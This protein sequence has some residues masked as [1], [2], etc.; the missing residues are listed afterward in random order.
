MHV[1]TL[2]TNS[3]VQSKC[4]GSVELDARNECRGL[5]C[6]E[7]VEG[8]QVCGL[9]NWRFGSD[10][11]RDLDSR[12]TAG[13]IPNVVVPT[14]RYYLL[15]ARWPGTRDNRQ[16]C[17][18]LCRGAASATPL[19][20]LPH[21]VTHASPWA[22]GGPT[23]TS[24]QEPNQTFGTATMHCLPDAGSRSCGTGLVEHYETVPG[25]FCRRCWRKKLTPKLFFCWNQNWTFLETSAASQSLCSSTSTQPAVVLTC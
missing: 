7:G 16:G 12:C 13:C 24:A 2:R 9:G 17:A 18:G 20:K 1:L 10:P 5:E 19:V 11:R 21:Q 15:P 25:S 4:S 8:M 14:T 3:R 22:G 6:C 23:F